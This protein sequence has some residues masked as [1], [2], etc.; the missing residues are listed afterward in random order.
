MAGKSG[1]RNS[2]CTCAVII[3]FSLKAADQMVVGNAIFAL[4]WCICVSAKHEELCALVPES[5]EKAKPMFPD[6]RFAFDTMETYTIATWYTDRDPN[7]DQVLEKLL[8]KCSLSSRIVLVVYGIPGKDCEGQYSSNSASVKDAKSYRAWLQHLVERMGE[9]K[10]LYIV[11]PDAVSLSMDNKCGVMNHYASYLN[12]AIELLSRNEHANVYLDVGFWSVSSIEKAN[13]LAQF[14]RDICGDHKISGIVLNTSNYRPVAE[15]VNDCKNF[16]KAMHSDTYRC[17]V[18]TSRDMAGASPKLEWCNY[19]DAGIGSPPT[20]ES[21]DSCVSYLLYVKVPG[22]SDGFCND[23][24]RTSDAARGPAAGEFSME[25]FK[26]LW[27]NGYF[28]KMK[29]AKPILA[30]NDIRK[31]VA[32]AHPKVKE[33]ALRADAR[34]YC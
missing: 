19:K 8:N 12:T 32:K 24:K 29:G 7:S 20:V 34:A 1:L 31:P 30:R 2:I 16:Q 25:L 26:N 21:P 33:K 3:K 10:V 22:H 23:P 18:D 27:N 4:F 11:E 17:V 15:I 9:R 14:I 5:Y 28:V 6:A 13:Q